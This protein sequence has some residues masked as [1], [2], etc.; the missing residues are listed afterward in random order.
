MADSTGR[1][2]L[3]L[4]RLAHVLAPLVR[5]LLRH[6]VDHGRAA[7][8]LKRVYLEE[9]LRELAPPTGGAAPTL[10]ALSLL[11]GL[12]RRDV[13][14]LLA[15][16][17]QPLPPRASAPS[18][19]MQVLARWASD[20][21]FAD[22]GGVPLP[23]PMRSPDPAQPTFE[24][25]AETVSKDIHAPA[26][27]AELVRLGL[28][29]DD[30]GSAQ[31]LSEGFVPTREFD[32]LLGALSRNGRDHLEA[33]VANVLAGD[34]RFLEYGLVADELRPASAEAL[35]ALA[36][37][38]WRQAYKRT[39]MAASEHVE[40]DR[41]LGFGPDA[42]E[43]RVRFGVYF[44]SEPVGAPPPPLAAGPGPADDPTSSPSPKDPP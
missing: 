2:E 24:R 42:P 5:L 35:H 38:L 12:Q 3:L 27:L 40:R 33:A 30:G 43:M 19:P 23:L 20:P 34:G 31:L 8:M 15:T 4:R 28:V 11:T 17:E 26:V 18:L 32:Q 14:A 37:K 21:A 22:A 9:A 39:V 25:L 1:S 16:R 41:A 10:T 13:K 6:G 44:Y 7:A 36:R 29:T